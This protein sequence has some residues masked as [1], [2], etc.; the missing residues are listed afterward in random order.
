MRRLVV[1]PFL[2]G[3]AL[4]GC[5]R[6]PTVVIAPADATVTVTPPAA[7]KAL[8]ADPA[9]PPVALPELTAQEK[10]DAALWDALA[11][12]ADQKLPEALAALEKARAVQDTEQVRREIARLKVRLDARAAAERTALD[13]QTVLTDGKPEQAALLAT[14]ALQEF[15]GSEASENLARLKRQA[16][17]L[18]AAPLDQQTRLARFRQEAEQAAR[19]NNLRAAVLAYEQVAALGADDALSRRLDELRTTLTRYDDNRRRAA[20]LRRDPARRRLSS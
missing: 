9:G 4:T 6:G 16:D 19:S 8:P 15:G 11:L 10:Y 18:V 12:V 14:A 5:S 3:P 20:E 17:A 1:L 2:L 7:D 13:I